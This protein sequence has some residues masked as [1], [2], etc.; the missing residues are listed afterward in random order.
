M[1][2][3]KTD[4]FFW[5]SHKYHSLTS[6]RFNGDRQ[7]FFHE[8]LT[9]LSKICK[10][11]T[12]QEEKSPAIESEMKKQDKNIRSPFPFSKQMINLCR[13][14]Q[15]FIIPSEELMKQLTSVRR[16]YERENR[17]YTDKHINELNCCIRNIEEVQ[18]NIVSVYL[19][20]ISILPEFEK[21]QDEEMEYQESKLND[22]SL[23][24]N[25]RNNLSQNKFP[26]AF[27]RFRLMLY[28]IRSGEI[29]RKIVNL[30]TSLFTI[31]DDVCFQS[32][33]EMSFH[34][35]GEHPIPESDGD[36][37]DED[38][39]RHLFQHSFGPIDIDILS[40]IFNQLLKANEEKLL[41]LLESF[42]YSANQ[43]D[44]NFDRMYNTILAFNPVSKE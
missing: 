19:S 2:Y 5:L 36:K 6:I 23:L 10:I 12:Q 43:K 24:D 1:R 37:D 34:L 4:S 40:E 18:K 31:K 16:D 27:D 28:H 41:L 29:L 35:L 7:T 3:R 30:S 22:I 25:I 11:K 20:R 42:I 26:G 38:L 33:C 17:T 39:Y 21:Q 9:E 44:E 14:Y 15:Q 8:I 32:L 13:V